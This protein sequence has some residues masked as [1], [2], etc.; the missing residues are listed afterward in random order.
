[1]RCSG[2]HIGCSPANQAPTQNHNRF[3]GLNNFLDRLLVPHGV[4]GLGRGDGAAL[5]KATLIRRS[6]NGGLTRSVI[7]GARRCVTETEIEAGAHDALGLFDI[8]ECRAQPG[9]LRREGNLAGAEIVIV[10][11]DEAGEKASEGIF[12]ADAD[13]SSRARLARR[14]SGPEDDRGRPIIVALPRA[15]TSDVAEEATPG[16]ADAA[17]HARQRA[18]LAVIGNADLARAVMAAFGIRPGIVALDADYEAAAKLI[19][20]TGLGAA[21][22]AMLIVLAERLAEKIAA[23]RA[24][25]PVF[26]RGP[27]TPRMAAKVAAA[28]APNRDGRRRR[29]VDG[30]AH[31]GRDRWARQRNQRGGAE[32]EFPHHLAPA[33]KGG[34]VCNAWTW[35]TVADA[36]HPRG[37]AQRR[38]AVVGNRDLWRRCRLSCPLPAAV[39]FGPFMMPNAGKTRVGT[40]R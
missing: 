31:V 12:P 39:G 8:D 32:Q 20:A 1:M 23:G 14:I 17:G 18:D 5:C 4:D 36:P 3:I 25:D 11:F 27:Q 19:V 38:R 22:Q 16:V 21:N 34:A 13:G 15:A 24:H 6:L 29:L 30:K 37:F 33:M 40:A 7:G 2:F 10:I 35:N 26:L 9:D 28:P